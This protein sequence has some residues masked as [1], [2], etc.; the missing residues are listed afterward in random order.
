MNYLNLPTN[1]AKAGTGPYYTDSVNPTT[2]EV[3]MKANPNY[4]G[5]P[6]N[7]SGPPISVSIKTLD[8][9]YIP[10]L[11]TRLLDAKAGKATTIGVSSSD[12]YSVAD[13]DQWLSNGKLV[14][15]VPGLTL[16]GP[17]PT[18][19]TSWFNFITNV[20]DM[21]VTCASSN[22]LRTYDGDLPS[23]IPST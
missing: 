4:W 7:W 16:D 18:F 9:V 11:G 10:D 19:T 14:S 3:V 6:K 5:G 20:T 12:I 2:Y 22:P 23:V 1:G 21:Q 17:Y 13:R 8:L 15:V